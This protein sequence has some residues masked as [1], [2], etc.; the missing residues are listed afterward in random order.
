MP[1][2]SRHDLQGHAPQSLSRGCLHE[3]PAC[4]LGLPT[5]AITRTCQHQPIGTHCITMP[6]T[7]ACQ[8]QPIGTHCVTM[9]ITSP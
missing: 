2:T 3:Q 1:W 7:S 5:W 4:S 9:P 6:I 8:H